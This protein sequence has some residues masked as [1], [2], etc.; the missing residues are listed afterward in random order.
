MAKPYPKHFAE[1]HSIV[2]ELFIATADDNYI[3]ARWCF[4]ENLNVDYFWL[5]VHCLEKYMKAVL[6]LNGRS[7][8]G[9]QHQIFGLFEE[10][11]K[12]ANDLLPATLVRPTDMPKE[13]WQDEA[14]ED[15]ISRIYLD[16]QAHNRYQIFGYI[17]RPVDLWKLDQVV[18]VVR[19]LC[20]PLDTSI[21]GARKL[22]NLSGTTAT[23]A[24][25]LEF[26]EQARGY[27]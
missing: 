15:F 23:R 26:A 1:K 17:R 25:A 24:E 12:F 20:Q 18:F 16:G 7:S 27:I 11:H 14:I 21:F 19:R 10:I 6:L 8:L 13:L 4:H 5:A 2:R 3:T 9:Y 22:A